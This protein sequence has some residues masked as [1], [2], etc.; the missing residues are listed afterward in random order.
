VAFDAT[1]RTVVGASSPVVP[2]VATTSF[3]AAE[4]ALARDGTL[5]YVAAGAGSGV[6]R[7]LVWVDRQGHET[8][9]AVPPRVYSS[10]RISPDGTR[11]AVTAAADQDVDIWLGDLIRATLTRVTSGGIN[12][13]PLWMPDGR[14]VVFSSS[15]AGVLNLFSQA[16][17]G[18][19]T[20][21]RVTESPNAQRASAVTPDGTVVFTEESSKTGADVMVLT[22]DGPRRVRPLVQ[23]PKNERSGIVSPD[24]RW[25]AYEADDSGSIEIYVR[26]FPEVNSGR[27]QVS[28]SGG[29]SP[30]WARSGHELFYWA[31]DATLMRVQVASGPA[32]TAGAPTRMFEGHYESLGSLLRNYDIAADG[33]RFLMIKAAGN[34]T[35]AP[36]QIVVVEHF[37]EEL[38]RLVPTK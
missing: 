19:G 32:W 34:A 15:R 8:P 6:A 22:L 7:T 13:V 29:T 17:D 3:G 27:W 4:A 24:G 33:Q 28:T 31:P 16:A 5:A 38:K 35:S 9:I 21:D 11:V 1:R 30:L 20:V 25:L 10:P 26:P 37:D 12:V 2:Q 23:T 36:P 14:R 18:T